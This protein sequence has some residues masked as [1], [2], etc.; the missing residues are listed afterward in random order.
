MPV[1]GARLL[2]ARQPQIAPGPPG[3]TEVFAAGLMCK[4]SDLF[5][6]DRIG[7][8]IR[9]VVLRAAGA[10]VGAGCG[11]RGGSYYTRPRNLTV[12]QRSWIN[13]SCYLDLNDRIVIEDGV[14]LGPGTSIIT[15]THAIGPAHERAGRLVTAPVRIGAGCWLGANVTVLPGVSVGPGCVVAAG[16]V[17]TRD[18][19][20]NVLVA[21]VPA[22]VIRKLDDEGTT[23]CSTGS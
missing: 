21:G 6:D 7:R 4:A 5:G 11:L 13:R 18:V 8:A 14:Q 17:V 1:S 22:R 20:A 2:A 9:R 23:A 19:P 15:T 10:R 12:G 16:A 3:T